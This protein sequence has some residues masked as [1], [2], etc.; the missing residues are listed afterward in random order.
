MAGSEETVDQYVIRNLKQQLAGLEATAPDWDPST[1]T[2][3]L[4][5]F[6]EQAVDRLEGAEIEYFDY[7][8]TCILLAGENMQDARLQILEQRVEKLENPPINL[9]ETLLNASLM[10]VAELVIAHGAWVA[11][12][13]L[14]GLARGRTARRAITGVR[15]GRLNSRVDAELQTA[16]QTIGRLTSQQREAITQIRAMAFLRMDPKLTERHAKALR[17]SIRQEGRLRRRITSLE[18]AQ[19]RSEAMAERMKSAFD[20]EKQVQDARMAELLEGVTA[21]VTVGRAGEALGEDFASLMTELDEQGADSTV[22]FETSSIL[23]D[24]LAAVES[25]RRISRDTWADVRLHVRLVPDDDFYKSAIVQRVLALGLEDE[26]WGLGPT[27]Y[28]GMERPV[29]VLGF[30]MMLW[31]YYFQYN[32]LRVRDVQERNLAGP[33]TPTQVRQRRQRP[34]DHQYLLR[35]RGMGDHRVRSVLCRRPETQRGA[36]RVPLQQVRPS[37]LHRQPKGRTGAPRVHRRAL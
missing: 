5:L 4:R 2:R 3:F 28:S 37:I 27:A 18:A 12:P 35:R 33:S 36:D 6:A 32:N 1:Q 17:E 20:A 25:D 30:E 31:L 14:Y 24:Y 11:L 21:G 34:P 19:V 13:A 8:A 10:L 26:Y 29:F 22:A 15:I 7:V 16:R 9:A 23:A